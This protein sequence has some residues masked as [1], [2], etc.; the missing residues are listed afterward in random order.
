MSGEQ[1]Q[2]HIGQLV[3]H[4]LFDYR[5]VIFDVDRQFEGDDAW[6]DA[7]ARSRPPRDKPWYHVLVHGADH[8]TYVAERNLD[9]AAADWTAIWA[10]L[11]ASAAVMF[12]FSTCCSVAQPARMASGNATTMSSLASV[13]RLSS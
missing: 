12:A 1:A 2:F 3:H 4:L 7:M 11:D 5:G 6:Y 8:T 10:D 13:I 9:A